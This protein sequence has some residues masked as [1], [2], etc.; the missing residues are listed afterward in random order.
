MQRDIHSGREFV[1]VWDL[2]TRMFHWSL[3]ILIVLAWVSRHFGSGLTW[4]TWNGYAILV[5]VVWRVLWGFV[6]SSTSRFA[7]FFYGPGAVLAYM[8]DFALRRP[9][10]FLGHNPLGA[11]AVYGLLGL[12]ALMALLGLFA[13]DDDDAVGGPLSGRVLE[14]TATAAGHW[15]HEL[16]DVLQVLIVVHLAAQVVYF[17]WKRENLPRAMVT[18]EKPADRYEDEQAARIAG[19]GRAFVCLLIAV[20][21]VFGG[22]VGAGGKLL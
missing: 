20:A 17:F 21:I 18:G 1:P 16:F 14:K 4:H 13:Y 19:T 3:A 8:R 10:H 22:I 12:V 6:G 11:L 15:H 9:R 7:S 2:P 5:L